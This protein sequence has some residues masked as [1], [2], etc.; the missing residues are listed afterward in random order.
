[1]ASA[2]QDSGEESQPSWVKLARRMS[3]PNSMTERKKSFKRE[4]KATGGS[5]AEEVYKSVSLRSTG[6]LSDRTPTPESDQPPSSLR[7]E[8][9]Y[10]SVQLKKT[11]VLD[12]S[13]SMTSN[14]RRASSSSTEQPESPYKSVQLKKT[15]AVLD[16]T[17]DSGFTRSTS[18]QDNADPAI[19]PESPYKSVELK[20]TGVLDSGTAGATVSRRHSVGKRDEKESPYNVSLRKTGRIEAESPVKRRSSISAADKPAA[21]AYEPQGSG[22]QAPTSPTYEVKMEQ[23][24]SSGSSIDDRGSIYSDVSLRKTGALSSSR[25]RR[26]SINEDPRLSSGST[27][28]DD[29]KTGASPWQVALKKTVEPGRSSTLPRNPSASSS[30]STVGGVVDYL[31]VLRKRKQSSETT[32]GSAAE[33]HSYTPTGSGQT[34]TRTSS[35]SSETLGSDYLSVLRRKKTDGGSS[36]TGGSAYKPSERSTPSRTETPDYRSALRRS[37]HMSDKKVLDDFGRPRSTSPS[38]M[39][40][41]SILRGKQEPEPKPT[42]EDE[43]ASSEL[44][45]K[46]GNGPAVEPEPLT[47]GCHTDEIVVRGPK[48]PVENVYL[49]GGI[50]ISDPEETD[51]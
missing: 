44:S 35:S 36:E 8:S 39:D 17:G 48:S 42:H 11:G 37:V 12:G 43:S 49:P 25:A 9:P 14:T 29:K 7:A 10:K 6:R 34:R 31:S 47:N 38:R 30:S 40:Y 16:A 27:A 24:S 13:A 22:I 26:S 51:L 3:N 32:D 50:R 18:R 45:L 15:G 23:R 41:R 4:E 2:H 33:A 1:M 28:S 46:S 5:E 20:K 21:A 19:R